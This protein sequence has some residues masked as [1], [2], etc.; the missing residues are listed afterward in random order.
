MGTASASASASASA[1]DAAGLAL[2]FLAGGGEMGARAR[3]RDWSA[4]PLGAAA[5]WPQS[6]RTAAS[7]CLNSPL[8]I[9]VCWGGELTQI[10]ND[11]WRP[12]AGQRHPAAFGQRVRNCRPE[13]WPDFAALLLR[14][15]S[16]G[17]AITSPGQPI[18]VLHDG[19][20][21]ERRFTIAYSPIRDESGGVGGVFC[22]AVEEA[23]AV[24]AVPAPAPAPAPSHAAPPHDLEAAAPRA[25]PRGEGDAFVE[26]ALE[27]AGLGL[28]ELDLTSDRTARRTLRHDRLFGYAEL[29]PTWGRAVAERHVLAEDRATLHQALDRAILTGH[30]ALEVRVRWPDGSVHWIALAGRT[31]HDADGRPVRMAGVVSDASERH[32]A[33]PAVRASA[34]TTLAQRIVDEGP[35]GFFAWNRDG[36]VTEANDRFLDLFGYGRED[37]AAG[38]VDWHRIAPACW[39][40]PEGRGA[41]PAAAL[42]LAALRHDGTLVPVLFAAGDWRAAD[43]AQTP[44]LGLV[45][46]DAQA[47][48]AD[49]PASEAQQREEHLLAALAHEVRNRLAPIVNGLALL[50]AA[51][52]QRPAAQ[53]ALA[54]MQRQARSLVRLVDDLLDVAHPGRGALELPRQPMNAADALRAALEASRPLLEAAGHEAVLH[55]PRSPLWV[56]GDSA[57][58]TH[59]LRNLLDNAVRYT[60]PGGRI[61]AEAFADAGAVFL[62]VA[63]TGRGIAAARLAGVFAPFSHLHEGHDERDGQGGSSTDRA[64]GASAKEGG[65]ERHDAHDRAATPRHGGLGIGLALA[66]E[67]VRRHGGD[68][69]AFSHGPGR[70]SRFLVRL[71]AAPPPLER[72]PGDP[73]A[74]QRHEEAVAPM[75]LLVV[76]DNAD[77]GD[78]LRL[79]LT[80]L[81]HRVRI[82]RDGA[83][84][85]AAIATEPPEVV[86]LDIGMPGMDGC[87]VARRIRAERAFDGT[88]LVAL[89]GHG[90]P[91]DRREALESGFDAHLVKPVEP[92]V[93]LALL[94]RFAAA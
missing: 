3:A 18:M 61:T 17:E 8:P 31:F 2:A 35:A 93:L 7:T 74:R 14:V 43:A 62:S 46:A 33:P 39:D 51:P 10:Y 57:Q 71:P 84:A 64:A 94:A 86:L 92:A 22:T 69:R 24:P 27:A 37:L 56:L 67:L 1:A 81:G 76:D 13:A 65:P 34:A 41:A 11:A 55:L 73:E 77:A 40:G 53:E 25:A 36:T 59:A 79:L 47:G 50:K 90:L 38:R 16:H 21:E 68:I 54:M 66:R 48:A 82:A 42:P 28:W 52:A 6:L 89:T 49:A 78:S 91:A 85:L 80:S 29:Q 26:A 75:H 45:I 70:G 15:W 58:L 60:A 23:P 88:K 87:E 30:L 20:L 4:T 5:G 19:A 9:L 72:A 63:D 83:G 12:L 44:R 32:A